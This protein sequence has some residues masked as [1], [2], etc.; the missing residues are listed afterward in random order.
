MRINIISKFALEI[1]K[2]SQMKLNKNNLLLSMAVLP[3]L[4][5]SAQ[6]PNVV[7]IVADDLGWGD[8]SMHGSVI[9][10]PN[11]DRLIGDGIE[12]DR[13]YTAPVSSPT[14][15]GLMTGRYPSR[16]G[17][18]STVIPPWRDYGLP[19]E[20]ETMADVLG[21]NGYTN[22]AAIGKWHM[23]HSR[24]RYYPLERGFTHFHGALNGAFDYFEHTREKELD[25]HDDW[26][27]CHEEGYS[28]DLI[29]KEAARCISEYAKGEP[30]LVYACFNAPHAPY[31]APED[32]LRRFISKEE[33]DQLPP[34]DQK[35]WTY[36]A[37]VSRMDT[38]VGTILDAVRNSGEGDNTIIL[39]MSDNGGVPGMEPYCNNRPLRGNK[40]DEWEGGLRTIAGIYWEKGFKQGHRKLDQVTGFVDILPTLKDII[41]DT[42]QP[43]N[44]YDGISVYGLL[45]GKQESID[46]DMY[47][48]IGAGVS[49]QYKLILAGQHLKLEKDFITDIEKNPSETRE[50]RIWE[51]NER[52]SKLRKTVVEGDAIVPCQEEIPYGKGQKGFV[53]P[54]E[55]KPIEY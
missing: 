23:G 36:R 15:C 13:F 46:R 32:E 41:G 31:Q 12:L 1:N 37:M 3:S 20:E 14:R 10:T 26:E 18:R 5:A 38:G 48:G 39:F 45:N 17:I 42:T 50:G 28:T 40:F 34:K 4:A 8:V 35:G 27:S 24:K 19:I 49:K 7:I 21:R 54:K 11:I 51:D 33:F 2:I 30:Y 9:P 29:A 55:W 16:F 6:K 22:R 52:I 53:A 47:L 25:W 44:P 43:K